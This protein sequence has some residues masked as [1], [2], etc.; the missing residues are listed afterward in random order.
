MDDRTFTLPEL[1]SLIGVEYRTL[2]TWLRRGLLVGSRKQAQGSGTR[3]IFDRRD[4]LEVYVLA[5]LRRAG[6]PLTTLEEVAAELRRSR[7]TR[8]ENAEVLTINGAVQLARY[9]EVVG[10]VSR[11]SPTLVYALAHAYAGLDAALL[12]AE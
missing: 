8:P 10:A 2:H 12:Q 7:D 11:A 4:A 1:A 9:D 6:L 5:D 3:N